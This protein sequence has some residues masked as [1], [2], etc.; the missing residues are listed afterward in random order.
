MVELDNSTNKKDSVKAHD[1]DLNVVFLD[2]NLFKFSNIY[3]RR[4]WRNKE[5][6]LLDVS[7]WTSVEV[8]KNDLDSSI[9]NLDL[10]DDFYLYSYDNDSISVWEYYRIYNSRLTILELYA[11]WNVYGNGVKILHPDK[12]IR[13]SN[14]QVTSIN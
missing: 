9:T 10:D 4:T 2:D 12:W 3:A 7:A 13:R 11:Q 1:E 14:L 8:L 5:F 6:W